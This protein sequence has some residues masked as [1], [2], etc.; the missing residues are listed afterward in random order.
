[1]EGF[2]FCLLPF[3]FMCIIAGILFS[4]LSSRHKSISVTWE[5]F[6]SDAGLNVAFKGLVSLPKIV[7]KYRGF[8]YI[9]ESVTESSGE[10]SIT[11][12]VITIKFPKLSCCN[13]H[14]YQ[15]SFLSKV[16]KMLGGQDIQIG[17]KEFDDSFIIKSQT[18]DKVNKLLTQELQR[19][20]LYGTHLINLYLSEKTLQNKTAHLIDNAQDLLYLSEIMAELAINACG[21]QITSQ[22]HG[23]NE[24]TDRTYKI[25]KKHSVSD[26]SHKTLAK[27]SDFTSDFTDSYNEVSSSLKEDKHCPYCGAS[28]PAENKYCIDCGR[29]I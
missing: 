13:L 28:S 8:D 29:E 1:M 20:M 26:L 4:V 7:G 25:E 23:G 12:T 10:D 14:V 16:G 2:C 17:N 24:I 19:K 27:S 9:L 15:E 21:E 5:K 22:G 11:Y 3:M 18:P 6:A